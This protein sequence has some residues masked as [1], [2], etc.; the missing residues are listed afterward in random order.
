MSADYLSIYCCGY[1]WEAREQLIL[2]GLLQ[3]EFTFCLTQRKMELCPVYFIHCIFT[4]C[5]D[6]RGLEIYIEQENLLIK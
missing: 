2:N 4:V 5:Q 1:F 3:N 6:A